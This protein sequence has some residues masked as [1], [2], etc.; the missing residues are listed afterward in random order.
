VYAVWVVVA[1]MLEIELKALVVCAVLTPVLKVLTC[2]SAAPARSSPTIVT[3]T[4]AV[5]AVLE[6]DT[7]KVALLTM[8]LTSRLALPALIACDWLHE[9][10]T[11]ESRLASRVTAENRDPS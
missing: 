5:C 11:P 3:T 2:V 6:R 4:D 7:L 8:S 9:Y 1:E 10:K